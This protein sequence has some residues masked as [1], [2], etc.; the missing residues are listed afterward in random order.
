LKELTFV[1]DDHQQIGV[2]EA[3]WI[4]QYWPRLKTFKGYPNDDESVRE[5]IRDILRPVAIDDT[6]RER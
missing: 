1:F 3:R 2:D 5:L 4:R 6:P